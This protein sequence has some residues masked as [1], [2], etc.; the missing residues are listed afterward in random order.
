MICDR[1]ERYDRY[2]SKFEF[3][4]FW[5]F[6]KPAIDPP[7]GHREFPSIRRSYWVDWTNR[8]YDSSWNMTVVILIFQIIKFSNFRIFEF[9]N[10][11]I[12]RV[13]GLTVILTF[14]F[15]ILPFGCSNPKR[16]YLYHVWVSRYRY[17]KFVVCLGPSHSGLMYLISYGVIFDPDH[18]RRCSTHRFA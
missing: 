9:L 16:V 4:N 1:Y 10:F 6:I 17:S 8:V 15:Y 2:F 14:E 5:I 13:V 7:N 3:L 12:S 18:F 11:W